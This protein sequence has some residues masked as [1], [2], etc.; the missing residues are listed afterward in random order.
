MGKS[1][2]IVAALVGA[3][4]SPLPAAA[5][6]SGCHRWHSCP[7]DSGSYECGDLGYDTYCGGDPDPEPTV[8]PEP[9]PEPTATAAPTPTPTPT[10]TLTHARRQAGSNRMATAAQVSRAAYPAGA[11]T[12]FVATAGNFPDA[13]AGGAAAGVLGAPVLLVSPDRV[14]Q[15]SRD[16]LVRLG[17]DTI[18]LLGGESSISRVVADELAHIAPTV[19]HAGRDRY[20]TAAAVSRARF[21]P[22][23]ATV[24]VASGVEYREALAA[25]AVAGAQGVPLLLSAPD[26]LPQATADELR[27]L[28]PA[29]VVLV[30]R[31]ESVGEAV[32]DSLAAIAPTTRIMGN[33]PY[34]TAVMLSRATYRS[35]S[36]VY[37]ATAADFP[38]ALAG[39]AAAGA[40]RAPLLFVGHDTVPEEVARELDRLRPDEIVVLGGPGAVSD[41]VLWELDAYDG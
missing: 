32:E 7:S 1:W 11:D 20:D 15:E 40:R 29:S 25:A 27:R 5:H 30:G 22:G 21:G 14:P 26:A 18:V 23:V 31:Y 38:D 34:G 13:L 6:Q 4:L 36:V 16:E 8:E 12:A 19:R 37:I 9:E 28:G 39:G 33:A 10:P 35:A 3:T 17:V 24:Y 41:A 2:L